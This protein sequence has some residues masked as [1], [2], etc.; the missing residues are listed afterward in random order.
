MEL[1]NGGSDGYLE[2]ESRPA[3]QQ[4]GWQDIRLTERTE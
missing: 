1:A 4:G 2:L 3:D